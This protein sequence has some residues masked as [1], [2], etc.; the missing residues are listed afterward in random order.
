MVAVAVEEEEAAAVV[1]VV[2]VVEEEAVEVSLLCSV[3]TM[4]ARSDENVLGGGG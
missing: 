1:E 4:G 2:E 3:F